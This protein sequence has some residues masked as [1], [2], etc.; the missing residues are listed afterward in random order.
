M[1]YANFVLAKKG[2]L[3]RVWL[4]AHWEKKLSKAHVFETDLES[5]VETI[6]SPKVKIALRTSGHL[7]LGVVRIYSRKAKYLLADC[8]EALIKIKMAFRPDVVDL[9]LDNQKAAVSTITLP[10]FQEWDVMMNN[11][12]NFDITATLNNNQCRVE[13][14]TMKEDLV[15]A[16]FLSDD[17]FFGDTQFGE[18]EEIIREGASIDMTTADISKSRIETESKSMDQSN[19][20]L[21]MDDPMMGGDDF[22]AGDGFGAGEGLDFLDGFEMEAGAEI[23]GLE[24]IDKSLD[25][26]L[27]KPVDETETA[28]KD[29]VE[30]IPN[31]LQETDAV[32]PELPTGMTTGVETTLFSRDT[33]A[34]ALEPVEVTVGKE[35][36]KRRKR[37]LVVDEEK[38]ISNV[39]MK[40]QINSYD[41]I[42]KAAVVAP[43]TRARMSLFDNSAKTIFSQ[44]TAFKSKRRILNKCYKDHLTLTVPEDLQ[45]PSS[46]EDEVELEAPSEILREGEN[47]TELADV[48][49]E[50]TD[51][52]KTHPEEE[53]LEEFIPPQVDEAD[54]DMRVNEELNEEDLQVPPPFELEKEVNISEFMKEVEGDS[55]ETD[56]DDELG[57]RW[58]KRTQQT[59]NLLAKG[60]KKK[61]SIN[62]KELTKRCSKK[63]A[64]YRFYTLLLL[65]KEKA[66]KVEQDE[67]FGNIL[68]GRGS[69]FITQHS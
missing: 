7:L 50:I 9:P 51:I 59:L 56:K 66:I 19:L 55:G 52:E 53:L 38:I 15:G 24:D 16:R 65:R 33:E 25:I 21:A 30:N 49:K 18:T 10:E 37:K 48:S 41:D 60:L 23:A 47:V 57:K 46:Q 67:L 12:G 34:F 42:V 8:T 68:I 28:D 11:M 20:E 61:D 35:K 3:A 26:T 6:I 1:F 5:S 13:E 58:T 54:I 69:R 4:A 45:L 22:G 17:N 64:A 43:P 62:F 31:E 32:V 40:E 44:P 14:I 39:Q 63:Q 36:R 27:T 2:P 29:E